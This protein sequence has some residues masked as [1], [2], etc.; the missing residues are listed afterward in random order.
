[1]L[2]HLPAAVQDAKQLLVCRVVVVLRA[3]RPLDL[4]KVDSGKE[5]IF[6]VTDASQFGCGG[7]LGLPIHLA[8]QRGERRGDLAHSREVIRHP[9]H[10]S[11]EPKN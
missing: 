7:W 3:L 10:S 2:V 6:L 11:Q 9:P 8:R 4:S 5:R 1:M